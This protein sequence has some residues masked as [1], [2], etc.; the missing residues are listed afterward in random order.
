MLANF[1]LIENTLLGHFHHLQRELE[2]SGL[3]NEKSTG[4]TSVRGGSIP[5]NIASTDNT[6]EIYLY[7][8]GLEV[9]DIDMTVKENVLSI[10]SN[11]VSSPI[12]G[13]V[14]R[15]RER[16]IDKVKQQITLPKDIDVEK[17]SAKY[18]NG[19]LHISVGKSEEIKSRK[20]SVQ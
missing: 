4:G 17:I 7:V 11:R 13:G 12:E 15:L 2:K 9:S 18:N 19:V 5:I 3:S 6:I 1:G 20:I 8:S 16:S 14:M 10:L